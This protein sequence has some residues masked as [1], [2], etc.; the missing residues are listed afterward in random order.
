MQIPY[1]QPDGVPSLGY[2]SH[3]TGRGYIED[4]R[5]KFSIIVPTYRRREHLSACLRGIACL[6]YPRSEFE[7]IVVDDGSGDPPAD[8]LATVAPDINAQLVSLPKNSGPATARNV[9][10]G[11]ARGT[12]LAFIDDD[13]IPE[14]GWLVALERRLAVQPNLLLGGGLRNA[15]PANLPAEASHQ[16]VQYLGRYYNTD[17]D[18]AEWFTSAN[19]ACGRE[20]FHSIGGFG[21]GF[22]LAAAED[23]DF[24]DRWHEAGFRL[25]LAPNAT[26]VHARSMTLQQFLSQHHTY[27][28]GAHYLHQARA[29][30]G[31]K[32][33]H[34]LEP[35]R[36]YW[37]LVTHPLS[38]HAGWRTVFLVLLLGLSQV[39]YA[40]GYFGELFRARREARTPLPRPV[41]TPMTESGNVRVDRVEASDLI[42]AES[43]PAAN[44]LKAS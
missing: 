37:G 8:V 23:R 32:I 42:A 41:R 3:S 4:W 18:N 28:R 21:P 31:A 34:K 24:C 33:T 35:V 11:R 19:I 6:E 39:A 12:W 27:G 44:A 40:A 17:P 25:A 15:I 22:P 1:Q 26:V 30:R 2:G 9:G 16:L 7:V 5:I 14:P 36:F 29:R 38:E 20:A 10:A 13:C 43:R